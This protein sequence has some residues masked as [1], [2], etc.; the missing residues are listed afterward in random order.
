MSDM[1]ASVVIPARD[2]GSRLE[3]TLDSLI[4]Q[5]FDGRFEVIVVASGTRTL[6]VARAHPIV[7]RALIDDSRMGPGTARNRGA[8]AAT[9]DILLFT[10]AD[11]VVPPPW[12]RRHCRHYATP[13]VA[14]VGG[15]LRPLAGGPAHRVRFRLL[16]DWWYRISW[17]LGFVQQPGS[18][19]SVR[20]SAFEA[21][22]G[23]D[24]SLSFL[25]DT[26]LSLR[27]CET[28][29]VVYDSGC[30]VRTSV[31]RHEREG[32]L[33]LLLA[34]LVGYLEYALPGRSPMRDHFS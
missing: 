1:D 3:R 28:G 14:G 19:C 34:Y 21:V 2:E 12:V 30:P 29:S 27:L 17:P 5:T 24:E 23:F 25:E 11:T 31:R 9:G 20:R 13:S 15:P 33:P 16:S 22:D 10:D 18:N 8:A 7:D 6:A 26:D 4:A 32:Y